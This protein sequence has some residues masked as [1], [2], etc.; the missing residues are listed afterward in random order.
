MG[1]CR[2]GRPDQAQDPRFSR[3]GKTEAFPRRAPYH[4][5]AAGTV[6]SQAAKPDLR[7]SLVVSERKSRLY[8]VRPN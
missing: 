1:K 4:R 2:A 5:C 6:I 8:N 7:N 3:L